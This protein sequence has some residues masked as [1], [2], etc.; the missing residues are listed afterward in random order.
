MT[1]L[2][3]EKA[4]V[5]KISKMQQASHVSRELTVGQFIKTFTKSFLAIGFLIVLLVL[6]RLGI[7][8]G[9]EGGDMTTPGKTF[10][11]LLSF[12]QSQR[13]LQYLLIVTGLFYLF[14]NF[15]PRKI[16]R[17]FYV[18]F[19]SLVAVWMIYRIFNLAHIYYAGTHIGRDFLSHIEKSSLS[20]VFDIKSLL[21]VIIPV[22]IVLVIHFL[23][24]Q[25]DYSRYRY[26][27]KGIAFL[28]LSLMMSLFIFF[29]NIDRRSL[30]VRIWM[31]EFR[32]R[33]PIASTVPEVFLLSSFHNETGKAGYDI[34]Q[35][36]IPSSVQERLKAFFGVYINEKEQYPLFKR[37]VFQNAFPYQQSGKGISTPN[38]II[39]VME[40]LSARLL[41][42]Y[43]SP[44]EGISPNIDA[45]AEASLVVRPF[46]NTTTPTMNGLVSV[47]CSHYPVFG[48]EE[49]LDNNGVMK[50]DLL[51]LPEVL[52]RKGYHSYNIVPGDPYFAVQLPFMKANGMDIIYGA[53]DIKEILKEKPLGNIFRKLA[54]SDRQVIGFLLKGLKNRSFVEPFTIT[55]ST[56]DLHPPFRLPEDC[57]RY[58]GQ[59]N[60]ILHIIH[61]DDAAF[62]TFW[63]YFKKSD[64]A[65]NTIIVLT[66]DHAFFPGVEYQKLIQDQKA[67][68]YDEVPFIIYDPTHKLPKT[69]DVTS[70]SVDIV[71]S[72]LHLLNVNIPNSFEGLSVFDPDGRVRYPNVLGSHH[73]LYFYRLNG[74]NVSFN[75]DDIHC[76]TAAHDPASPAGEETFTMCDYVSWLQYKRW[77]V[78]N[79]LIWNKLHETK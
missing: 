4:A 21:F 71:P 51:C 10:R 67:G 62:G 69:L 54:Y 56:D 18:L 75:R 41:G 7:M 63:E 77:L 15:I 2:A 14:L 34:A 40:S 19:I 68:L 44:F 64:L 31:N 43:G 1:M 3:G 70:S 12:V 53:L 50:F 60:A 72:M 9:L 6:Y 13:E 24:K 27:S 26:I 38:I 25:L 16:Y 36:T 47:L 66:S 22:P 46:Y 73:Y 45:F 65:S 35:E 29:E 17:Y 76:D 37:E 23:L 57:I 20:M 78:K 74:K 39:I 42:H 5:K 11:V 52:K 61:N 28:L 32:Y 59:D 48:Q 58:P 49:W 8:I 33:Y 30:S 79:D 55:V